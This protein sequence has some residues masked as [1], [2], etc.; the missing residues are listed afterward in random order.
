MKITKVLV[1]SAVVACMVTSSVFAAGVSNQGTQTKN[2]KGSIIRDFK[3]FGGNREMREGGMNRDGFK[4]QGNFGQKHGSPMESLVTAGTITQVQA[5]AIQKAME[6][7]RESKTTMRETLDSLVT[8]GTITQVQEDAIVKAQ[9]ER[10]QHKNPM[11]NLVTAG[12]IT[13]VQADAIGEAL[14]SSRDSGK[15]GKEVLDGLVTA[16]TITQAQEDA[17]VKVFPPAK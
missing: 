10:G 13:Q 2:Q 4:G 3:N 17:V 1:T 9:P 5:D 6:A 15:T 11:V 12:T 16:G 7:G 14:K 8:A